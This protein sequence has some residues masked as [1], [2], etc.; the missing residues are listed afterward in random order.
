MSAPLLPPVLLCLE[1]LQAAF[2]DHRHEHR[3]DGG[4][5]AYVRIHDLAL[6]EAWVPD[7]TWVAFPVSSMY[8]RT[9]IYP[10][11]VRSDLARADGTALVPPLH[12]GQRL[13]VWDEPAVMVSRSSPRWDPARDTAAAKL[14]RVLLWLREQ[15]TAGA[16]AA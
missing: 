15:G 2:S 9:H 13:P 8:P 14:S 6:G 12:P 3:P 11:F 4:G 5:G 1:E 10:H 7:S 16:V